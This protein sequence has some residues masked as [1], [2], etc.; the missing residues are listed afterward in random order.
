MPRLL[1]RLLGPIQVTLDGEPLVAFRSDKVRALLAF[2][3]VELAGPHRREKLAGLLWPDWPESSARTNLRQALA[4]LRQVIDDHAAQPSFLRISRQTIQ[5]NPGADAW[6]DV[7]A[8]AELAAAPSPGEASSQGAIDA[9][10]EAIAL[11]RG[12]FLEGFSLPDSP[13]FEEWTLV[14][15]EQ[16]RRL[17]I[18]ALDRL[19]DAHAERGDLERALQR[20]WRLLELAPW[21]EQA[22]RQAMRLLALTGQR[23]AALAQYDTCRR[24]LAEGLDV[25][26]AAETTALVEQIR[27]G[28][29]A[30]PTPPHP[31]VPS[32]RLPTALVPFVGRDSELAQ[33]RELLADPTCRLLTLIGPGGSGKT[34]LAVEAATALSD[35]F[36]HGIQFVPLA[37][38]E[39][40][41]AIVPTIAQAIGF[42]FAP[43]EGG[44]QQDP[45]E[46]LVAYLRSKKMLLLVDNFEHLLEGARTITD[47][48]RRAPDVKVLA[49]SRARLNVRGEHLFPVRGMR[50]PAMAVDAEA[51]GAALQD[52][53]RYSA[54]ALFLQGARQ[55]RPDFEATAE[56]LRRIAQVCHLVQGMPLGILLAAGWTEVLAPAEIA[57]E[58]ERGLDFLETGWRAVP[59]RQR[60]LRAVFDHSW[61][62]LTDRE[63]EAFQALSVFRG[64]FT[65]QAAEAVGAS[66]RDL[67][68]LVG[69]SLLQQPTPEGRYEVHELLR[70]YAAEKLA[71][72]PAARAVARDRH[73]A[74]YTAALARFTVDLKG[75][76]Q[77]AAMAEI[78]EDSENV[79]AAWNWA[80][81]KEQIDR[82]DQAMEGLARFYWRRG[83]YQEGEA[84]FRA[85][86]DRL[87]AGVSPPSMAPDGGGPPGHRL[88]VLAR[89]VAWHAYF[90]RALGRWALR[91]R[92]RVAWLQEQSLALLERPELAGQDTRAE[93][94]LITYHMGHTV[95]MS[96]HELARQLFEQSLALHRALDDRWGA[97]NDLYWLGDAAWFRG[98]YAEARAAL[99]ESLE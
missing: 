94:A 87:T 28:T 39:S 40:A 89:G 55:A 34:R 81:E 18:E 20:T 77:R 1:V 74:H 44:A 6:V 63:R 79:R 25:E 96:D 33:L 36:A 92:E 48:L 88:R 67:K 93:R 7:N 19:I 69:K 5:F 2:L 3:C 11:Y 49:T 32:P 83:R 70:Q 66:L 68:G 43:A 52:V 95:F 10:G 80:A 75:P 71:A 99:Q 38:V 13:P 24:L 23:T 15:R 57:A 91:R 78:E 42:P 85:A 97:A 90:S 65:R 16:S 31:P 17:V 41:R 4:N 50:Y 30:A 29:L 12:E 27:S 35:R 76:R 60:S 72:S 14:Q 21:R 53:A 59:E 45:G 47:I 22:H 37:P 56:D 98:A 82:L 51:H 58:I 64:G 73:S 61:S 9:L 54:I 84:A 26:P 46:Q 86:V 62:L 8:F